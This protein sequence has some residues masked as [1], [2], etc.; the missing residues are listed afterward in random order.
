MVLVILRQ[1]LLV[2]ENWKTMR[3]ILEKFPR[4][5]EIYSQVMGETE[6][7]ERKLIVMLSFPKDIAIPSPSRRR[8]RKEN[9]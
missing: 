8:K 4:L 2:T 1:A 9:N 5:I 6:R 7:S 3:Q